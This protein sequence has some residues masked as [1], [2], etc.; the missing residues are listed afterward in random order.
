MVVKITIVLDTKTRNN[1]TATNTVS[2]MMNQKSITIPKFQKCLKSRNPSPTMPS[3]TRR[4]TNWKKRWQ[5]WKRKE[6][7]RRIR[8]RMDR[9]SLLTKLRLKELT[10]DSLRPVWSSWISTKKSWVTRSMRLKT[11]STVTEGKLICWV[12][13]RRGL[14]GM[15]S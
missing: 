4:L 1:V 5:D 8:T 3:T 11:R 9:N 12:D 6:S 2:S 7:R 14:T 13:L 15:S 10:L